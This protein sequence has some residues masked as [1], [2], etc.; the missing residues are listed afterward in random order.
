MG[1]SVKLFITMLAFSMLFLS[2]RSAQPESGSVII[3]EVK[4]EED[5]AY[6]RTFEELSLGHLFNF[7]LTLPQ[8]D[9]SWVTLWVEGYRR[10]Q[11]MLTGQQPLAELSFGIFPGEREQG[12]L[13]FA[14]IEAKEGETKRSCLF[15]YAPGVRTGNVTIDLPESRA[16]TVMAAMREYTLGDEPM[17]LRSGET[18]LLALYRLVE[19]RVISTMDTT[20]EEEIGQAIKSDAA[21]LLLKIKV[22][23]KEP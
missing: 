1:R 12:P 20:N 22:E 11:P 14:M 21:I 23:R 5:S 19:S 15:L 17:R 18:R 3:A 7:D 8:A 9:R 16:D 6:T 4:K 2:C 10:G 13:G